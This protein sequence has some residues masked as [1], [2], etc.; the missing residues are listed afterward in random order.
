MDCIRI[1]CS[2][3]A[4]IP[5]ARLWSWLFGDTKPVLT[6]VVAKR[7]ENRCNMCTS[8][9]SPW[10]AV[11]TG[12]YNETTCLTQYHRYIEW[13]LILHRVV[14]VCPYETVLLIFVV[15]TI[16][17]KLTR[18]QLSCFSQGLFGRCIST[19]TVRVVWTVTP[20]LIQAKVCN[21]LDQVVISMSIVEHFGNINRRKHSPTITRFSIRRRQSFRCGRR[22]G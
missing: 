17:N 15:L 18:Y 8:V 2:L 14:H 22:C 5:N 20:T 7:K 6:W 3:F 13:V 21:W 19:V 10:F 9:Q 4:T 16:N 1:F 12:F 11:A